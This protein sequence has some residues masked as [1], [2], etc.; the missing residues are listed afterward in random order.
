MSKEPLL[1]KKERRVRSLTW[2]ARALAVAH[3]SLIDISKKEQ[4][5]GFNTAMFEMAKA[6]V[7]HALTEVE[8]LIEL[9]G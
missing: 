6:S 9:E 5:E 7:A 3:L 2:A 1:R 8:Y 4:P